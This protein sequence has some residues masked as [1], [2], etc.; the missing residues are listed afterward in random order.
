MVGCFV[1]HWQAVVLAPLILWAGGV[2]DAAG[3]RGR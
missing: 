2:L 1:L 3:Q